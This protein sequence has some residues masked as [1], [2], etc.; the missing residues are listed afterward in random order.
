MGV[1]SV[2]PASMQAGMILQVLQAAQQM[3]TE[4]MEQIIAVEA[5]QQI[6]AQRM[7]IAGQIVDV[8]A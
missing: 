7:E 3:Q 2:G 8:Y 6:D 1:S 5:Q 4:M